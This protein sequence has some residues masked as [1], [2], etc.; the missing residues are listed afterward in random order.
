MTPAAGVQPACVTCIGFS[1]TT[2]RMYVAPARQFVEVQDEEQSHACRS[3]DLVL[4]VT[5][6]SCTLSADSSCSCGA[7]FVLDVCAQLLALPAHAH[8]I[9][10]GPAW[11]LAV[12][13]AGMPRW[14]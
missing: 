10:E 9:L 8:D 14:L 7:S 5:S 12:S 4:N 1:L 3:G 13:A 6:A 2:L 11:D